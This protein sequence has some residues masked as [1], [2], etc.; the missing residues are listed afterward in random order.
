M[1]ETGVSGGNWSQ[2]LKSAGAVHGA[3]AAGNISLWTSW[4]IEGQ[5]ISKGKPLYSF[6]AL[7]GYYK[8][9]RPGAVRIGAA[10][11]NPDVMVTAYRNDAAHGGRT[12]VVMISKAD[13]AIAVNLEGGPVGA[14]Y[15]VYQASEKRRFGKTGTARDLVAL[16]ARSVTTLVSRD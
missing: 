11:G 14:E 16:P 13:K 7:N 9:V 3:L 6:H 5:L 12:V 2:A 1:T 8:F 4:A 15:E 10:C